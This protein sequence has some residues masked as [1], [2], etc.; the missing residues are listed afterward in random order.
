M[1]EGEKRKS[2]CYTCIHKKYCLAA[3]K[4]NEYCRN[5]TERKV[6]NGNIWNN[7]H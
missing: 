3:F 2:Q 7:I 5:H 4:K 6:R 1:G